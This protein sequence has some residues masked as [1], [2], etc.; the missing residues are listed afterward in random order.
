MKNFIN[1]Y[2]KCDYKKA[3]YYN[4]VIHINKLRKSKTN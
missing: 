4:Y 2:K 3:I 1:E